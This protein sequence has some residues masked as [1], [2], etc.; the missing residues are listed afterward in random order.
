MRSLT[1]TAVVVLTH[2]MIAVGTLRASELPVVTETVSSIASGGGSVES[3]S[4]AEAVPAEDQERIAALVDVLEQVYA[5]PASGTGMP[6]ELLERARRLR[7]DARLPTS[8]RFELAALI[9]SRI[10]ET[11]NARRTPV[12]RMRAWE[13]TQRRLLAE[14]P[15][16]PLAYEGLLCVALQDTDPERAASIARELI[17]AN[18]TPNWVARR[19]QAMLDSQALVGQSLRTLLPETLRGDTDGPIAVGAPLVIYSWSAERPDSAINA[20]LLVAR[21][22]EGTKLVG[23]CLDIDLSRAREY[24]AQAHLPGEQVYDAGGVMGLVAQRL[25]LLEPSSAYLVGEDGTVRSVTY[26]RDLLAQ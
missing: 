1:G 22:P 10:R 3:A 15:D 17:Q 4:A 11:G 16:Q 18:G 13:Q 6:E 19:A 20:H 24:A 2:A 12:E 5:T 9:E 21:A 8:A 26:L 23:V 25:V 7:R 14:F